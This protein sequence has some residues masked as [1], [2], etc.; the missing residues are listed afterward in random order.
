[1]NTAT[2]STWVTL[3]HYTTKHHLGLFTYVLNQGV[4]V[5]NTSTISECHIATRTQLS[6]YCIVFCYIIKPFKQRCQSLGVS[7]WLCD[8]QYSLASCSSVVKPI[9]HKNPLPAPPE[10]NFLQKTNLSWK[11]PE[12]MSP[13]RIV[14]ILK[15]NAEEIL[16]ILCELKQV[17]MI[18]VLLL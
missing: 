9:E 10:R 7:S 13:K 16:P 11:N 12:Q 18:E 14:S 4:Q 5:S 6:S 1:M 15:E 8:L 17:L 2:Y 3:R